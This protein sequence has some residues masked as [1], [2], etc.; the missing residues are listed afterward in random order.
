MMTTI[1]R[2]AFAFNF[3]VVLS[4]PPV[5]ANLCLNQGGYEDGEPQSCFCYATAFNPETQYCEGSDDRLIDEFVKADA[6]L[7]PAAYAL[8]GPR[9][10]ARGGQDWMSCGHVDS[11]RS[12]KYAVIGGSISWICA[13]G[14]YR[15]CLP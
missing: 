1:R 6:F 12:A 5:Y 13:V 2:Y 9:P 10:P 3:W 15:I 11:K 7:L 8:L 4:L 14:S